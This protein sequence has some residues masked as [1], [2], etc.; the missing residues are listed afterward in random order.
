[1]D[2]RAAKAVT[3]ANYVNII[4]PSHYPLQR[5]RANWSWSVG[6]FFNT[7]K[8]SP[9]VFE[10][11]AWSTLDPMYDEGCPHRIADKSNCD[12]RP[13]WLTVFVSTLQRFTFSSRGN[14]L[15]PPDVYQRKTTTIVTSYVKTSFD[16]RTLI[17]WSVFCVI[18]R[19]DLR[20]ATCDEPVHITN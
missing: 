10:S 11:D 5:V 15:A 14:I 4:F 19:G 13:E 6:A 9:V 1:M 12:L 7:F 3:I 8:T 20:F 17:G 16:T 18:P 2:H